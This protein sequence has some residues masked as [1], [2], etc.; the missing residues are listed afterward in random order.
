MSSG[1]VLLANLSITKLPSK[2]KYFRLSNLL[3]MKLDKVIDLSEYC[4][5]YLNRVWQYNPFEY[6]R[7]VKIN[8]V[9]HRD[10]RHFVF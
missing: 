10:E 9:K 3:F 6:F 2:D 7:F 4:N 5:N 8:F 1:I